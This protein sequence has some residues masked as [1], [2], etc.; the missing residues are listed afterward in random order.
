MRLGS[1]VLLLSSEVL[2]GTIFEPKFKK[3]R[4]M[5]PVL[6]DQME[7]GPHRGDGAMWRGWR[8]ME[9]K[10]P[11]GGDGARSW[12]QGKGPWTRAKI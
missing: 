5:F 3:K 4:K 2:K 7:V 12:Y 1:E 10:A 6:Q 9:P 11:Y 8:H